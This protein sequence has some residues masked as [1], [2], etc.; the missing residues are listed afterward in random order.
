MKATAASSSYV[1]LYVTPGNGVSIQYRNGTGT[2]AIDLARQTGVVAPYWV[3]LVRSGN[4]FS[5]YSSPDGST[6]TLV[7][8]TN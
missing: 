8:S 2:S 3:K 1:G 7:G 6:W 4:T 5:G